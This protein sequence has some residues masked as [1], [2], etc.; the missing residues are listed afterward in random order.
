MLHDQATC[1]GQNLDFCYSIQSKNLIFWEFYKLKYFKKRLEIL[2]L[3]DLNLSVSLAMNKRLILA[4]LTNRTEV[5][6]DL[7]DLKPINTTKVVKLG[8]DKLKVIFV[9]RLVDHR[10]VKTLMSIAKILQE[11]KRSIELTLVGDGELMEYCQKF[12]SHNQLLNINML[13]VLSYDNTLAIYHQADVFLFPSRLEEPFG[14]V[15]IEAMASG[16]PVIVSKVGALTELVTNGVD[17][18]LVD[19]NDITG[20]IERLLL[21]QDKKLLNQ[22]SVAALVKAEHF[23]QKSVSEN[24]NNYLTSLK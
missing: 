5:V 16:L 7:F 21:L 3:A 15:V 2:K 14:R 1:D 17:G 9:G 4:G 6:Y 19:I 20:F 13:G 22:M 18:F 23:D 24:L 12:I 11:Q 8:S 10:G